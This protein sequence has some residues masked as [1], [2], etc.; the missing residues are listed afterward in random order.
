M[1]LIHLYNGSPYTWN[2]SLY[3]EYPTL[4]WNGGGGGGGG[5]VSIWVW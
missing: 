4:F 2:T 3:L 5:E 1:Q